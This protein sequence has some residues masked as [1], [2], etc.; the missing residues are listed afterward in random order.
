MYQQYLDA[1][2]IAQYFRKVDI[3][4]TMT[5]NPEWPEILREHLPGQTAYDHP[6]IVVHVFCLKHDAI[7]KE[8]KKSVFDTVV[9]WVY[10]IEF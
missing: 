1:M 4:M 2:A 9:T 6:D 10:T 3:F 7:L 8:I 5:A